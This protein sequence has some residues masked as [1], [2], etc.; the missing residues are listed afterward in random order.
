MKFKPLS[1][2]TYKEIYRMRYVLG[3]SSAQSLEI[4]ISLTDFRGNSCLSFTIQKSL[5]PGTLP[6]T[7]KNK[8][9]SSL[10]ASSA[11]DFLYVKHYIQ[12]TII[13]LHIFLPNLDRGQG[14]HFIRLLFLSIH[15]AQ[16]LAHC[17]PSVNVCC[18][19]TSQLRA[20][21]ELSGYPASPQALRLRGK[22]I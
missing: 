11:S 3:L 5:P 12:S 19:N 1:R 17:L 2:M 13:C 22:E 16:F 8:A 9:L 10:C 15:P 14:R 18:M 20:G 4:S 7:P 6:D 21:L